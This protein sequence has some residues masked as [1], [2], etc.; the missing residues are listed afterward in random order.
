MGRGKGKNK[1]TSGS[2]KKSGQ[3]N[4]KIFSPAVIF[5]SL[6]VLAL[7][8]YFAVGSEESS[9]PERPIRISPL[10]LIETRPV[11]APAIFRGRAALAYQYAAEIPEVLDN[12]FCYCHCRL[13]FNHKTL[14]TCFTGD[15]GAK[16]SICQNEVFRSYQLHKKG[17]SISEISKKIDKEFYR[18]PPRNT[19]R[20]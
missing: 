10:D 17:L 18:S 16:C 14:L 4:K 19:R 2:Y 13:N 9:I 3:K 20:F 8:I 7:T 6:A 11:L 1:T 12:Q 5:G 15:H